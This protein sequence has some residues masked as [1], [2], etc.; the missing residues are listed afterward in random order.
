MFIDRDG[1]HF[2]HILNFLRDPEHF[3][4]DI[5]GAEQFELKREAIYYGLICEMFPPIVLKDSFYKVEFYAFQDKAGLWYFKKKDG[6]SCTLYRAPFGDDD[7]LATF[8]R[9]C[10]CAFV[11]NKS[12][13]KL[14]GAV[15]NF[16]SFV[17]GHLHNQSQP[18]P[19]PTEICP[20]CQAKS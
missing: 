20:H 3:A 5:S 8:C 12:A 2:R 7:Y 13:K 17:S 9:S 19:S 15:K 18:Y 4:F 14:H 16:L 11:F 6:T 1:T 10:G